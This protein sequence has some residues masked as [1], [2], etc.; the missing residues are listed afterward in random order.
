M[1]SPALQRF[2]ELI[3]KTDLHV[4]LD[5]SLRL[6]T[7][8][9]LARARRVTLP[10]QSAAGLRETVF[11]DAYRDL[12]EYLQGFA[13][14]V[15][16]LQD[17]EA[18]EQVAFEFAED[19]LAEGV[20][21]VEVRFAPQ[22]HMQAGFSFRQVVEAVARGM[23]RAQATHN[24]SAEVQSGAD[25]PFAYGIIVCALRW[26]QPCFSTY[27]RQL[28]AVMPYAREKTMFAAAS[29]E[30]ARAATREIEE[31]GL[32]IVGFDLAGAE[33]G[34]PADDHREAFQHAH[35]H[36]L[37]KTVHAGEAYGPESIFQ[38]ITLCHA[39]RIGHGTHLFAEDL[40]HDPLIT[41]RARY[42]DNL[43]HYIASQR[44]SIEVNLTSN[45]Q[46]LPNLR[47]A[48]DHPLR[49]MLENNL[50]ATLCTDNRLVS[51]TTVT[52]E[53]A[54]AVDHLPISRRQLRN[55][56]IAGFKGS[57]YPGSYN[58]KR[59]TIRRVIDRYDALEAKWLGPPAD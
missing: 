53:L 38:A 44:I 22:L 49:R 19:N 59:A 43:V 21:Y 12:P 17:A 55:L 58:E 24:Q 9:D 3:P 33:N 48:A 13:Y 37:R 15:A 18:L 47:S 41:D 6:E 11:K 52:R 29:L 2:L 34:Y 8:I 1:P 45:L 51:N 14:T 54:L 10:S 26:F 46:T 39:N 23:N 56:V 16:V 30:L 57:F 36:F 40:I 32:P 25:L 27:Y 42:V 4:H 28:A 35:R 20:R 7:L 5:G 50:S 31:H